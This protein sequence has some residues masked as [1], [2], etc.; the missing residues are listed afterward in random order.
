[1]AAGQRAEYGIPKKR[2]TE[3]ASNVEE[4]KK[5]MVGSIPG[6]CHDAPVGGR[7]KII[8]GLE[9]ASGWEVEKKRIRGVFLL[10]IILPAFRTHK[11]CELPSVYARVL[12]L[13]L[14]CVEQRWSSSAGLETS[15]V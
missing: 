11:Q 3:Q 9:M 15:A 12:E 10:L 8:K 13:H 6:F 14:T 5:E 7:F 2:Q 1:M 4:E